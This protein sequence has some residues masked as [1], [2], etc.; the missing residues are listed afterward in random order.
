MERTQPSFTKMEDMSTAELEGLILHKNS[1]N[2][3]RY[4]L[5]KLM[6][7]GLSDKVE[8]NEN[9]GVNWIKEAAKKGSID[10]LEYK[11]YRDI[12]FERSPNIQKIMDNL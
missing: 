2:D 11:T 6:I 12:R 8:H 10:A 1:N 9:K 5:G 4:M 3:A 7:E